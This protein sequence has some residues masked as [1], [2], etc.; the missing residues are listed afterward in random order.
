MDLFPTFKPCPLEFD[1]SCMMEKA[2]ELED[3]LSS[4]EAV[5]Q[6]KAIDEEKKSKLP[7]PGEVDF[8]NGG[9][10]CQVQSPFPSPLISIKFLTFSNFLLQFFSRD[11]LE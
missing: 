11:S 6:A 7:L 1:F 5:E 10:P 4:E 9:P 2:G 8:I 3:C